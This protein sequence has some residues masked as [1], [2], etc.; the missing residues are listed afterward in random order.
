[1]AFTDLNISKQILDALAEAG[2]E[3]PTPIQREAF[4]VIR[5]G[6]DMIGIA[7]T[8]TGKTLAYLIP[9]LMK[10]HYAQG[11]YPR[12]IVIVPTRELVVQVCESVELLTEYMDI[13]C[14]GIYGG[15]NI[16][17]QQN[18][19]YEGVDLLVATPGRFMDI[20]MN[21][22]LRT[23]LVK[24]VVVDEADRL[25]DLGFMPQLRSILEVIPEKHQTLLFS[26]TFST[27]VTALASEFMV[28]PVKVEVAPQA[29]PVDTV[30]QLRYDVPNI[31][32]KINLLKLL[33]ADKEEYSRVMVF[34]E[35][36]KN[37][38]RITDKLAD[39][40]KDE[41]SVIHSNKAQ[42]TRLN[43]LRAFREGRSRIMI[44]SDVAAR[45]IDIQ[46]VSHV[47][48][49]D[50]PA[51]PEEYVHRIGRTARAGKEG[52]A[53]S[54]VSPKEEERIEMIEQLIGQ[55]IDLQALPERLEISDV[56]LDEEKIQTANI[57]YQKGR[58]KGGGA[59]H[60]RSA[61]N[62]KSPE[63][64]KKSSF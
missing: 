11:K 46:D 13:R 10:L 38:D 37:A 31:M 21:G 33:L 3:E 12:A 25:M 9:I 47:V 63:K 30:L 36:K 6:K 15:T 27:A 58:P 29:T 64:K 23:P 34:T 1:M 45:G 62:S 49:F 53:I 7:R 55:K 5:S 19:V 52:V 50:I 41:L 17:T 40:W 22:M 57:I 32:T 8:G 54:L 60:A 24:T 61:K 28:A 42:N 18:A 43:A 35:S 39:Y 14:V 2:F 48:N 59:F 44:A 56:L 51:L 16:R 20:Y 4:P 26:A